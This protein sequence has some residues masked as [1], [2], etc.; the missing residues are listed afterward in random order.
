MIYDG[1]NKNENKKNKSHTLRTEHVT[2]L[3]ATTLEA[4]RN[5]EMMDFDVFRNEN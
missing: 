5:E 2:V 3:K 1:Q 4:K